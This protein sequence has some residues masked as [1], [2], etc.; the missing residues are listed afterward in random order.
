MS[1]V[2]VLRRRPYVYKDIGSDIGR[3]RLVGGDAGLAA[4]LFE[5]EQTARVPLNLSAESP[6]H[7]RVA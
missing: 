2:Q 1:P 6:D 4:I 3:L 7:D 5:R